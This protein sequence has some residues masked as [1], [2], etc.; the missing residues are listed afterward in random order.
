MHTLFRICSKTK[1]IQFVSDLRLR[2]ASLK[3]WCEALL[4]HVTAAP[5]RGWFSVIAQE[6]ASRSLLGDSC[7]NHAVG[8]HSSTPEN[9]RRLRASTNFHQFS[10]NFIKFR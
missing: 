10:L 5:I 6:P 1:P 9:E 7:G 2:P 4:Y 3:A 8:G